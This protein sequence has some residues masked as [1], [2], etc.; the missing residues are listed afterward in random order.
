M[1]RCAPKRFTKCEDS[2]IMQRVVFR[3]LPILTVLNSGHLVWTTL[4][5]V[6]CFSG[7]PTITFEAS[8]AMCHL[9]LLVSARVLDD[10]RGSHVLLSST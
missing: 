9:S 2:M 6:S 3:S 7:I 10:F 8:V 5:S 1:S 4:N